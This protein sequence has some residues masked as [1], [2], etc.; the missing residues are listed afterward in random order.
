MDEM[1]SDGHEEPNEYIPG[2]HDM[3]RTGYAFKLFSSKWIKEKNNI[4]T[5][6]LKS[7]QDKI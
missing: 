5:F 3:P 7:Q 1:M 6:I 2:T 4:M